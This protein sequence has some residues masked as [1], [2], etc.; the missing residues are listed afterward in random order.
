[1]TTSIANTTNPLAGS[2]EYNDLIKST[3]EERNAAG[4]EQLFTNG[5]ACLW[6]DRAGQLL[7]Q[8]NWTAQYDLALSRASVSGPI[9]LGIRLDVNNLVAI[10]LDPKNMPQGESFEFQHKFFYDL[11]RNN[12]WADYLGDG[13]IETTPGTLEHGRGLHLVF[14][15][16][17][18]FNP[19]KSGIAQLKE[20]GIEIYYGSSYLA[21]APSS[22]EAGAYLAEDC[23]PLT[24]FKQFRELPL[25]FLEH[26][27]KG[28]RVRDLS[29][30]DA[31]NRGEQ[32]TLLSKVIFLAP[33]SESENYESWTNMAFALGT[34]VHPEA[35]ELFHAWSNR[36][37]EKYDK[38]VV[39]KKW[40]E[41]TSEEARTR[42]PRRTIRNVFWD[43]YEKGWGDNFVKMSHYLKLFPKRETEG[44]DSLAEE[45]PK[46]DLVDPMIQ[47]E[48]AF[49]KERE[50]GRYYLAEDSSLLSFDLS[51]GQGFVL[52]IGDRVPLSTILVR[53]G[54]PNLINKTTMSLCAVKHAANSWWQDI[55]PIPIDDLPKNKWID[56]SMGLEFAE[57]H[58]Q[59]PL[60]HRGD[61]HVWV[62]TKHGLWNCTTLEM[63]GP[64]PYFIA[65][66]TLQAPIVPGVGDAYEFLD[67]VFACSVADPETRRK[68]IKIKVDGW[69]KLFVT[70]TV[71]FFE[72][73]FGHPGSGK[74]RFSETVC[75]MMFGNSSYMKLSQDSF[76]DSRSAVGATDALL[77]N[78]DE[79]QFPQRGL[80]NMQVLSDFKGKVSGEGFIMNNEKFGKKATASVS[81]Y[82]MATSNYFP[83]AF[84]DEGILARL[85]PIEYSDLGSEGSDEDATSVQVS[86][87]LS[88]IPVD[89]L[90]QS[91]ILNSIFKSEVF[92]ETEDRGFLLNT[93]FTKL[94]DSVKENKSQARTESAPLYAF[95]KEM[96]VQG[97]S[98]DKLTNLALFDL[99]KLYLNKTNWGHNLTLRDEMTKHGNHASTF[100]KRLRQTLLCWP[101]SNVEYFRVAETRGWSGL[102]LS[103]KAEALLG[104]PSFFDET[105]SF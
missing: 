92:A 3:F 65:R 102:K 8:V 74:T 27:P 58:K 30:F 20:V 1:M 46:W 34:W 70:E 84:N 67:R 49:K 78:V 71:K 60:P 48:E 31:M 6:K 33:K 63:Y 50:E 76:L 100:G 81:T 13:Y 2:Q 62:Q 72:F 90:I 45:A 19:C 95:V 93:I 80:V 94:R 56:Y 88:Q 32:R 103:P 14:K 89:E 10:D 17:P 29:F 12:G 15:R 39:D 36:C 52:G 38:D 9:G 57:T 96:L 101:F 53:Q 61:R 26:I 16:P 11:L 69:A 47:L 25:E 82:Y 97:T 35:R 18:N 99:F 73:N 44:S 51:I 28:S 54:L 40:I 5:K 43:A 23:L 86:G 79:L 7:S 104:H 21:V 41:V 42:E 68:Y 4:L 91:Q 85:I 59:K 75:R 22:R 83:H 66:F 37:L 24:E 55:A 64:N 98:Y 87:L 77:I 105:Q